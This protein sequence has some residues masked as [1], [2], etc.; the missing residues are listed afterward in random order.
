M[1]KV[2]YSTFMSLRLGNV[3]AINFSVMDLKFYA[4]KNSGKFCFRYTFYLAVG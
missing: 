1:V 2:I 4:E 3:I